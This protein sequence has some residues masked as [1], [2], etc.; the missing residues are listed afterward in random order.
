MFG[1]DFKINSILFSAKPRPK[2]LDAAAIFANEDFFIC[3]WIELC[4]FVAI[5][6]L[7]V[8]IASISSFDNAR[9]FCIVLCPAFINFFVLPSPKPSTSNFLK[10]PVIFFSITVSF[11]SGFFNTKSVFVSFK[12]YSLFGIFGR[13]AC[14]AGV[15]TSKIFG[16]TP[17]DL[18]NLIVVPKPI[19]LSNTYLALKQVAYVTVTP[20]TSIGSISIFGFKYP[21]FDGS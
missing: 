2:I 12:V 15:S 4:I 19:L 18:F 5:L 3:F 8:S 13:I 9:I 20:S 1:Y 7:N 6:S 11:D 21:S 10:N 16:I 14:S 17:P